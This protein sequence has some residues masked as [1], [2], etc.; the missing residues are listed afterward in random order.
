MSADATVRVERAADGAVA[1]RGALTFDTAASALPAGLALIAGA[2]PSAIDLAINL[3]GVTRADSAGLALLVE[4]LRAAR[5][6]NR[7]LT[8]RAAPAQ[9]LAL[10]EACHLRDLF[11]VTES[12]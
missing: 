10:A 11:S 4:W 12:S 1:V 8:F 6:R 5:G 2:A 9:L 7:E 3:A